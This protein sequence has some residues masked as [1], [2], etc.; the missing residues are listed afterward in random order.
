MI[1]LLHPERSPKTA[2]RSLHMLSRIKAVWYT[3]A[4]VVKVSSPRERLIRLGI[5]AVMLFTLLVGQRGLIRLAGV[6][7]DR[8]AIQ[9]D[10]QELTARQAKL[11]AQLTAYTS[12]PGTIEKIVREQLDMVKRGETVYKFPSR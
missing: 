2:R 7:H 10:I 8:A 5:I 12:D 9:K 4:A 3:L 1:F 6:L 11:E